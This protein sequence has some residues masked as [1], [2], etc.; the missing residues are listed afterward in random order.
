MALVEWTK[1]GFGNFDKEPVLSRG[2]LLALCVE[3]SSDKDPAAGVVA[4]EEYPGVYPELAVSV[5]YS[6][7]VLTERSAGECSAA[8]A[9]KVTVASLFRVPESAASL[10]EQ[11]RTR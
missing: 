1:L 10:R 5:V 3:E 4:P 9:W 11:H 7:F 8:D 6:S 2:A